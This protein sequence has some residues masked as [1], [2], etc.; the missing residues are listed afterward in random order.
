MDARQAVVLQNLGAVY[1][2]LGEY[3]SSLAYH[4]LA[5]AAHG[6]EDNLAL[7]PFHVMYAWCAEYRCIGIMLFRKYVTK[8]F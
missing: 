7:F 1:N 2:S 8:W 4:E 5:C 3:E 6:E